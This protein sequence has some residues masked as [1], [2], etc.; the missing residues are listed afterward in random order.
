MAKIDLEYPYSEF[1]KAGYLRVN[2]ENRKTLYLVERGYTQVTSSTSYARYLMAVH[3]KR[4]LEEDEQVDHI[5]N[6]KTNDNISN[7]QILSCADNLKKSAKGLSLIDLV[8]SH[9]NK[10]FTREKR[11]VPISNGGTKKDL[12]LNPNLIFCSYSCSGI[13]HSSQRKAINQATNQ[14]S[15]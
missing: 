7:L 10:N 4:I 2:R 13:Y 1:Y 12:N 9:C 3:L 15:I 11:L 8:C 14:L 5:D 6:D